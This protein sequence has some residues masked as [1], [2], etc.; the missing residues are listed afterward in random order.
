MR[1]IGADASQ[2]P[3]KRISPVY[4]NFSQREKERQN[5]F[6]ASVRNADIVDLVHVILA[7]S[8]E[9]ENIKKLTRK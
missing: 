6:E 8:H 9:E 5:K 2:A 7:C 4:D 1:I 3:N